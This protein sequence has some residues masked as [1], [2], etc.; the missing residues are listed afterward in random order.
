[1]STMM[2]TYLSEHSLKMM[3]TQSQTNKLIKRS[4]WLNFVS[5]QRLYTKP[6]VN[7]VFGKSLA[8]WYSLKAQNSEYS[9]TILAIA[10]LVSR[11]VKS[12]SCVM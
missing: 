9:N 5:I 4:K 10:F 7:L 8:T 12:C 3:L 6:S 2:L 11:I 1:M